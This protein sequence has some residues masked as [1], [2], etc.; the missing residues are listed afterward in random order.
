MLEYRY[1]QVLGKEGSPGISLQVQKVHN[2]SESLDLC[3]WPMSVLE[4]TGV[5]AHRIF[6]KFDASATC[7]TD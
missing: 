7:T 1:I 3:G 6:V 4:Q 5:C 2:F